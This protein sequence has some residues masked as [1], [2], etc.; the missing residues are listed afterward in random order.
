MILAGSAMAGQAKTRLF[1]LSGQS[2]MRNFK[3][4]TTLMP[5]LE[6]AFPDNEVIAVKSA[7]GGAPIMHWYKK[8][9]APKGQ[10]EAMKQYLSQPN[11]GT[12]AIGDLYE[13][14]IVAVE[15]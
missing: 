1:I 14:L 8:W 5:A 7:Q 10:E 4:S 11:K 6:K 2:N 13:K 15:G 3:H 12:K 9:H